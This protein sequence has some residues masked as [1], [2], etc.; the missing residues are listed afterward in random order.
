MYKQYIVYNTSK[1]LYILTFKWRKDDLK[2]SNT[3]PLLHPTKAG[4]PPGNPLSTPDSH[5]ASVLNTGA[6]LGIQ[7][8]LAGRLTVSPKNPYHPWDNGIFPLQFII[9]IYKNQLYKC[10]QIY[11]TYMGGMGIVSQQDFEMD[12]MKMLTPICPK[13]ISIGLFFWHVFVVASFEAALRIALQPSKV[14][15]MTPRKPRRRRGRALGIPDIEV[16]VMPANSFK[17]RADWD[18]PVEV[19]KIHTSV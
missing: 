2:D 12:D 15:E 6:K 18:F 3:Q 13:A 5:V 1:D 14:I 9:K 8:D 19:Q 10:G 16:G 7:K 17:K 11:H 4:H